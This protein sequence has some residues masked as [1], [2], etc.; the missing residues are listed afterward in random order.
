[1][2]KK[3]VW[4]YAVCFAMN[5]FLLACG[6]GVE[7]RSVH[8]TSG[9]TPVAFMS[10]ETMFPDPTVRMLAAAAAGGD[11]AEVD[12]LVGQGVDVNSRGTRG[13]TPLVWAMRNLIGFTRLLELGADPNVVFG[14]GGSV[15]LF[16]AQGRN[17]KF[18]E[19]ALL[20]GGDPNLDTGAILGTPLIRAISSSQRAVDI[21]LD[22]GADIEQRSYGGATPMFTAASLAEFASVYHLLNRGADH[23]VSNKRGETFMDL[24][25]DFSGDFMPGHEGGRWYDK[26]IK[27]L[28]DR[29]VKVSFHCC[30]N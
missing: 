6:H 28:Q 23:E 30:R 2:L 1:M 26:V 12:R 25:A 5:L 17:L 16:A 10:L 11:I 9:S 14:Y 27:Q 8:T 24:V 4:L 20:H 19:A 3:N 15:M 22:A 7:E 13:A 21:L 18:L 29:G